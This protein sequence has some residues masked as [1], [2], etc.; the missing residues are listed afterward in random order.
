MTQTRLG[1]FLFSIAISWI[2]TWSL[3]RTLWYGI[4]STGDHNRAPSG[5]VVFIVLLGVLLAGWITVSSLLLHRW[6]QIGAY[7]LELA[8]RSQ[9]ARWFA[10]LVPAILWTFGFALYRLSLTVNALPADGPAIVLLL[11][12]FEVFLHLAKHWRIDSTDDQS[13]TTV[14]L[15]GP[16]ARF[17][18]SG[19]RESTRFSAPISVS[20]I[21][22]CV[23][24]VFGKSL[25]NPELV[26]FGLDPLCQYK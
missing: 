10:R 18:A 2:L 13:S 17:D 26:V 15:K 16:L 4:P 8:S 23:L 11:L 12:G 21:T 5:Y 1:R 25:F 20:I 6:R 7:F 22:V 3:G 14:L 19:N 9:A 24:L